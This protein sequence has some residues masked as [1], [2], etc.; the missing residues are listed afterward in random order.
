VESELAYLPAKVAS[1]GLAE[2]V[3]LLGEHADQKVGAAEV[4]VAEALE[5]PSHLGLDLDCIQSC[6]AHNGICIRCYRQRP[7]RLPAGAVA[8]VQDVAISCLPERT[9]VPAVAR[10]SGRRS[11]GDLHPL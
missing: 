3:G 7:A 11:H 9:H 10:H 6:H 8:G 4:P 2:G 5:P 1:L